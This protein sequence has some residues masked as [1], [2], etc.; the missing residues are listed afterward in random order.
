[1]NNIS[2]TKLKDT[3]LI[4]IIMMGDYSFDDSV[5]QYA[6]FQ[7]T[8]KEFK[9]HLYEECLGGECDELSLSEAL[10][11]FYGSSGDGQD[12]F[13]VMTVDVTGF[14]IPVKP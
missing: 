7:G 3:A 4:S 1:M 13:V 6:D 12:N 10:E 14:P 9:T 5:E 8:I 11:T 2:I